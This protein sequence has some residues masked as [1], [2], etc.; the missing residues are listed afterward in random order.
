MQKSHSCRSFVLVGWTEA[1]IQQVTLRSFARQCHATSADAPYRVV[2]WWLGLE[3]FKGDGW[4]RSSW[5]LQEMDHRG[6]RGTAHR[7]SGRFLDVQSVFCLLCFRKC[8]ILP[9]WISYV[10]KGPHISNRIELWFTSDSKALHIS[11]HRW[12]TKKWHQLM[13]KLRLLWVQIG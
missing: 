2:L 5:L 7:K 11:G 13:F 1:K 8:F 3:Q 9:M 6:K 10:G 4:G 12:N